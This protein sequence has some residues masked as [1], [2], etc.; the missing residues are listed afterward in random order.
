MCL[1]GGDGSVSNITRFF[2]E[3]PS[4][5]RDDDP[6]AI[7]LADLPAGWQQ[8]LRFNPPGIEDVMDQNGVMVAQPP[9]A[10]FPMNHSLI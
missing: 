1:P 3:N 2:A 7:I 6:L 5:N 8:V 9:V 4:D 10:L